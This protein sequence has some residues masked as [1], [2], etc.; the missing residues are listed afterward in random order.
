MLNLSFPW[1]SQNTL[2]AVAFFLGEFAARVQL[3]LC[4]RAVQ[5]IGGY[6]HGALKSI[7]LFSTEFFWLV[8]RIRRK[9]G[10]SR[11]LE[12]KA[13]LEVLWM[14]LWVLICC[15]PLGKHA[16]SYQRT[17]K[18]K[19]REDRGRKWNVACIFA[20]LFTPCRPRQKAKQWN[21][22][23]STMTKM[24]IR[25]KLEARVGNG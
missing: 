14:I 6:A 3:K 8:R 9:G 24:L 7:F 20:P 22:L 23:L 1:F 16:E 2:L 21:L 12:S 17:P 10:T 25:C 11:S 5:N 13:H 4:L 18:K 19:L 15:S